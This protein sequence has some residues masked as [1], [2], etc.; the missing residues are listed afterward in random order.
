[1]S[2]AGKTVSVVIATY[3]GSAFIREQLESVINQTIKPIEIIVADDGSSDET[4]DIV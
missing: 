3:N 4:L 2:T 1:M